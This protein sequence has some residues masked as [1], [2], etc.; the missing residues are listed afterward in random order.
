MPKMTKDDFGE[1]PAFRG[2]Y[3]F[4]EERS[5][6]VAESCGVDCITSYVNLF[7]LVWF[8]GDCHYFK[9]GKSEAYP[10][11]RSKPAQWSIKQA[12]SLTNRK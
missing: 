2:Y 1:Y 9:F 7:E 11:N 10:L 3:L 8:D 6:T 12:V 5:D 4:R